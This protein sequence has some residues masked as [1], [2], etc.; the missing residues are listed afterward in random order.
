MRASNTTIINFLNRHKGELFD[1]RKVTGYGRVYWANTITM[2][3]YEHSID[4]EMSG[5]INGHKF[6]DISDDWQIIPYEK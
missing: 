1:G 4:A 5:V 3:I 6:A 2:E